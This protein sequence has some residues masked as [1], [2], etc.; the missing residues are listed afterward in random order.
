MSDFQEL[1]KNIDK[2]RDYV[3]DF[4]VYGFKSRSDFP[5]KSARTYDDERRRIVSWLPDYVREDFTEGGRS[6]NISLQIDQKQLDTNPLF[7]V[8]QTKSFT[9][10]DL[11]LHFFILK[12]LENT[13]DAYSAAELTD[14]M[15]DEFAYE[16]DL[17]S[18]RRKCNEYVDEGLLISRKEGKTLLYSRGINF[19]ELGNADSLIDMIRCF[20]LDQ[21][22]GFIGNSILSDLNEKNDTF[23]V[24]HSFPTFTLEDG[25]LL[26]LLTAIHEKKYVR[27]SVQ[28]RKQEDKE[29]IEI[30]G[31]P[32]QIFVSTRSGRRFVC[33]HVEYKKSGGF[34]TYRLDQIKEV[35]IL[36]EYTDQKD[37]SLSLNKAKKNLWGV[38]FR[39]IFPGRGRLQKLSLTIRADE[40]WEAYIVQRLIREGE[41]GSVTKIAEN[42]FLY[43]RNVADAMEM[44]PWIRSF[45]GRI[46]DLKIFGTDG[47]RLFEENKQLEELFYSDMDKM[48]SL[49]DI[50]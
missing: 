30:C 11:I 12:L 21:P 20:Q 13:E 22:L 32:L 50:E 6:K 1:I 7:S 39:P 42:T 3:R 9:D 24:K 16:A 27:I 49:Y 8:W 31:L 5:G 45:T 23:R 38:S 14:M 40:K 18:V 36:E 34:N 47:E 19:N 2:C 44:F 15:I 41:G 4:F 26:N 25:I 35:Q 28:S 17:Q 33:M 29:A 43:E 37:L 48:L 10:T 46:I